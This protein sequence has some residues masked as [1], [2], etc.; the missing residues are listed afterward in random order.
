MMKGE[1]WL[2]PERSEVPNAMRTAKMDLLQIN[3]VEFLLWHME[4]KKT[5]F[6]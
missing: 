6:Y 3:L 2:V 4:Q 1:F 5:V